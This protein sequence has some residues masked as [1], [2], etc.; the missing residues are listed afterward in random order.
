MLLII[1]MTAF[2]SVRILSSRWLHHVL[3]LVVCLVGG[4]AW[5]SWHS[6]E[7]LSQS[8]PPGLEGVPVVVS[9]YVCDLPSR[10]SFQS[11]RF[12]FCVTGWPGRARLNLPDKLRLAWYHGD[13]SI[14]EAHRLTLTVT[15]KRPHGTLNPA[16]FRY[17]DW[18][19]RQGFRATG[20]VQSASPASSLVCGLH[21]R[22]TRWHQ[23]LARWVKSQFGGARHYPLIASLMIGNRGPVTD[24]QWD[25]LKATGTVH[26]VAISG[27]HL[28]LIAFAVGMAVRQ[29]LLSVPAGRLSASGARRCV[30]LVVGLCC[31][32]YALA[33]GFTVPTRRALVMAVLAMM[34]TMSGRYES[35]WR[36]LVI[37]LVLIL[38]LDP[39]APLDQGFWLSFSAVGILVLVFSN[40]LGRPGWLPGLLLAQAGVFVGLAPVLAQFGQ[41]QPMAGLLANVFAI[42]W[43]S[44]VVMPV[45]VLGGLV[46]AALPD[47]SFLALPL[48]N[49]VLDVLWWVLAWLS[50]QPWPSASAGTETLVFVAVLGLVAIRLSLPWSR[51]VAILAVTLWLL[52]GAD[53][54]STAASATPASARVE[55]FDVGQGLSVL[56]TRGNRALLYDT[57][58]AVPGVFSAVESTILPNLKALGVDRIDT[59]VVSHSDRD[60]SGG[61]KAL[62]RRLPVDHLV[63][64]E[65]APIARELAGME[66]PIIDDCVSRRVSFSGME[67]S[68]WRDPAARSGN[69]ASCVLTIR[70]PESDVE[71]ILPGDIT[72]SAEA[73]FLEARAEKRASDPLVRIVLAP[74]HGSKSSSSA[75]WVRTLAPDYVIYSAGY[76]HHFGHPHPSVVQRY[77]E[78]GADAL[79]TACSGA[80]TMTAGP[81]GL[82]IREAVD[83]SPFWIG[84]A[85]LARD[86]CKIP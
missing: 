16:G 31:L 51:P 73:R 60:H 75:R 50:K 20:T 65:P 40:R 59:L 12:S 7:R 83:E 3:W 84:G 41:S 28:G 26:L 39:F 55:V 33:S 19:F 21:C 17:E 25:V 10:G 81:R 44:F 74:H 71:W 48:M 86:Q 82:F 58:P 42:P 62:F 56:L 35:P 4:L 61:L 47:L 53:A 68:F 36:T 38:L 79:N 27:L 30:L 34:T 66:V 8:L 72:T 67:L 80:I 43:V 14:L 76:H 24:T 37:A 69:D 52:A 49:G 63:T 13:S 78:V 22:Y 64:G 9:G 54:R 77:R 2:C 29:L 11:L 1:F 85:G 45:I 15:L 5:G 32:A 23:S 18:L 70:D 57:G 46:V 6:C